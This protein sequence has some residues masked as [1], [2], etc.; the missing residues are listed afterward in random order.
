MDNISAALASLRRGGFIILFDS[1]EREGEAD[2]LLGAQ[3]A[4]PR[5]V[6]LMR[7]HGGGLMCV[8]VGAEASEALGLPF[9]DDLLRSSRL[10]P[11]NL[12]L[13]KAKY[14]DKSAFSVSVNH[15]DTFTGVTDIDRATTMRELGKLVKKSMATRSHPADE[16]ANSFKAPG[17]V[18]LLRSR[19]LR[20]RKG[21]TELS[22]VLAQ[23][24]G[25]AP[26][27]ALCEMLDGRTGK[28]TSSARA[29]LLAK[30]MNA[31][32]IIGKDI[33]GELQ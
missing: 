1:S 16:F 3:F 7:Q 8:A 6:A 32:F 14:G 24:A 18:Q 23:L 5:K 31:P 10:V 28:A 12:V 22:T 33:L 21:H 13:R 29:K 26:A 25:I 27:V 11:G 15:Q 19:S 4:T 2:I 9:M 30:K 17:H 20:N